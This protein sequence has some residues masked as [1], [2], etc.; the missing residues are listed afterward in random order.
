MPV[1]DGDV[2]IID[3]IPV[4]VQVEVIVG[5]VG[6]AIA[7]MLCVAVPIQPFPLV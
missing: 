5:T 3:D 1:P 6:F 2:T 7:V 4:A